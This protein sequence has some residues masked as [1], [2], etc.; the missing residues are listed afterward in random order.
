[1]TFKFILFL[2]F[3]LLSPFLLS[4]FIHIN[5]QLKIDYTECDKSLN[6]FKN[7][8]QLPPILQN[9]LAGVNYL[10]NN[11]TKS[12]NVIDFD[13]NE[14]NVN[15]PLINIDYPLSDSTFIT[16][17]IDIR[18][19]V[20]SDNGIDQVAI[21]TSKYPIN[22]S[23]VFFTNVNSVDI[24]N[25]SSKWI[26]EFKVP[27]PGLYRITVYALDKNCNPSWYPL[28]TV[29]P[30]LSDKTNSTDTMN[31]IQN[32]SRI[33]LV[34]NLFSQAM[35]NS[36]LVQFIN[37]NIQTQENS[38]ITQNVNFLSS[39]IKEYIYVDP[40]QDFKINDVSFFSYI[41]NFSN[42]F[43]ISVFNELKNYT[44]EKDIITVINDEDLHQGRIFD[45]KGQNGFDTLIFTGQEFITQQ[46]YDNLEK[47][48]K[49]GGVAI[50]LNSDVFNSQI[51]YDDI[52]KNVT[53]VN[54]KNWEFNGTY[55]KKN[56]IQLPFFNKNQEFLGSNLLLT[57]ISENVSFSNN[58]F[59]YTHY[60]ENF[61][62]KPNITIL[63]DYGVTLPQNSP[64]QG[65]II[66]TYETYYGKGKIIFFGI[67]TEQIFDNPIFKKFFKQILMNNKIFSS[68]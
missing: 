38:L 32:S 35:Y 23:E 61:I 7:I 4:N 55:A 22:N 65:S 9:I 18:G 49:N 48:V 44:S 54:G 41:L 2:I 68:N 57:D 25:N 20:S 60:K 6:K 14:T 59:N 40:Y 34:D 64:F 37:N 29:V 26:Y 24:G 50:F 36:R 39:K 30:F 45:S 5:A 42:P 27:E 62:N 1:M 47:F 28:T 3:F 11:N 15:S 21:S 46:Y 53:L 56:N 51:I 8:V 13:N 16:S 31:S 10:A 63:Y 67:Y 17:P 33:A 19:T 12:T 52:T 66:A 43:A 58:P